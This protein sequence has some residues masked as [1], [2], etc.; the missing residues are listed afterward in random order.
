VRV[1]PAPLGLDV[2]VVVDAVLVVLGMTNP[3]MEFGGVSW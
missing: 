1:L 2:L 3:L